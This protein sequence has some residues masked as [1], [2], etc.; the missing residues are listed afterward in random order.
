MK[1]KWMYQIGESE[2]W[3]NSSEFDTK[4]EAVREGKKEVLSE[5]KIMQKDAYVYFYVGM[6]E[7]V[8][9]AGVD[10]EWMLENIAENTVDGM[11]VGEDY[12]CDVAKE[13][14]QELEE[15]LNEVLFSWMEKYKYNPTFFRIINIE[16]IML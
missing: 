12:L 6:I 5:N 15:K 8:E 3:S 9:P 2:I 10:V 13:Q 11:E 16:K 1:G 7:K 4:E 14:Q